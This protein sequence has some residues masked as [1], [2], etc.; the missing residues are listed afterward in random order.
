MTIDEFRLGFLYRA[1][2]L[3]SPFVPIYI[4]VSIAFLCKEL[5]SAQ[6]VSKILY[7]DAEN[8]QLASDLPMKHFRS[9]CILRL[10][11]CNIFDNNSSK[12]SCGMS[13]MAYSSLGKQILSLSM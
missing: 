4:S 6:T 12:R 2:A 7:M 9:T 11:I 10:V 3:H 5:D 8:T 1:K 13:R